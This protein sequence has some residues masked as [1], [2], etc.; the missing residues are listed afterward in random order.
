MRE[1]HLKN[2][3]NNNFLIDVNNVWILF[4]EFLEN[5]KNLEKDIIINC[6]EINII[7][8]D[9]IRVIYKI[10]LKNNFNN[11]EFYNFDDEVI[12]KKFKDIIEEMKLDWKFKISSKDK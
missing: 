7:I 5:N 12:L 11:I 1:I 4:N 8:Y 10:L 3:I 6:S 9:V 2:I